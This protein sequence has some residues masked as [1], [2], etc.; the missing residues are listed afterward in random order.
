MSFEKVA[1][2]VGHLLLNSDGA[3]LASGGELQNDESTTK[4]LFKFISAGNIPWITCRKLAIQ[5][6]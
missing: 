5:S 3:I 1:G 4:K 2:S 6:P